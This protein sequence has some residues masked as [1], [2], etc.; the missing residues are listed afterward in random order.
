MIPG[1]GILNANLGPHGSPRPAV[2]DVERDQ[3]CPGNPQLNS[4]IYYKPS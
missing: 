3:S 1:G 4:Q 2:N